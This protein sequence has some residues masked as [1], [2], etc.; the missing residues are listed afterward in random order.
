[1]KLFISIE[2]DAEPL[3]GAMERGMLKKEIKTQSK[4]H[5]GKNKTISSLFKG[6]LFLLEFKLGSLKTIE[7]MC[8]YYILKH[9]CKVPPVV[10]GILAVTINGQLATYYRF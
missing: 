4:S 3:L 2:I 5:A 7:S 10:S 9:L 8:Y 6:Y 1:M